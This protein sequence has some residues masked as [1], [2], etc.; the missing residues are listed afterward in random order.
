MALNSVVPERSLRWPDEW[1][2]A[3]QP[4]PCIPVFSANIHSPHEPSHRRAWKGNQMSHQVKPLYRVFKYSQYPAFLSIGQKQSLARPCRVCAERPGSVHV[5]LQR[6]P[7]RP[8]SS[9]PADFVCLVWVC[10]GSAIHA[11]PLGCRYL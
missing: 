4:L 8:S 6:L 2:E 11:F 9:S 5:Q 7:V 1:P 10:L 3:R